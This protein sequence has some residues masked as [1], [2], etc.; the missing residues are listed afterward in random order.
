MHRHL[1]KMS[2]AMSR[3]CIP[4]I[5]DRHAARNKRA[6]VVCPTRKHSGCA[7]QTPFGLL[8]KGVA[9][10]M[11]ISLATVR[12]NDL[13][14]RCLRF[15][16]RSPVERHKSRKGCTRFE[17]GDSSSNAFVRLYS[18]HSYRSDVAFL[19]DYW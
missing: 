4:I 9:E 18:G 5:P 16:F 11:M 2:R 10:F 3:N 7:A 15:V 19:Q 17:A 8:S 14:A 6:R 13:V 12:N 1:D